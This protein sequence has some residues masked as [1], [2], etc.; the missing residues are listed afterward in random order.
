MLRTATTAAKFRDGTRK[1][2]QPAFC[3]LGGVLHRFPDHRPVLAVRE[4]D[5][6]FSHDVSSHNIAYIQSAII[7]VVAIVAQYEIATCWN[8][9]YG[10]IV[11]LRVVH[12]IKRSVGTPRRQGFLVLPN[13]PDD[14]EFIFSYQV[15]DTLPRHW[16]TVQNQPPL[17]HL[18][19]IARNTGNALHI[20]PVSS[21]KDDDVAALR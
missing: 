13:G 11:F 3:F 19:S 7:G 20:V 17:N 14:S 10:R 6:H 5:D 4:F 12:E 1:A 9:K 2:G 15:H 18:H 8:N 21:M 16:H